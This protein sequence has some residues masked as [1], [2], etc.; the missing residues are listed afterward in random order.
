MPKKALI[1]YGPT[2]IGKTS[3]AL[4]WAQRWKGELVSADSRQVYQGMDI[5]T[6]KDVGQAKFHPQEQLVLENCP[7][8]RGYYLVEGVKI[9]LLDILKPSQRFSSYQWAQLARRV[10]KDIWRRKKLPLVVGGSAFY[11]KT[12]LDDLNTQGIPPNWSLRKRL[13]KC[14]V[15]ELQRELKRIWPTRWQQLNHSDRHNPRR[16]IR[17]LEIKEAAKPLSSPKNFWR[18]ACWQGVYL[19]ASLKFIRQ[20]ISLRIRQRLKAGLL[21]EIAG[22]LESGYRWE[23]PGLN[24]LAYKEFRL[25]FAGKQQRAKAIKKWQQDEVEYARRQQ[26]WFRHDQRFWK[27]NV[28]QKNWRQLIN[29]KVE[30]WYYEKE[31]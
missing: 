31:K 27:V 30:T 25:F 3:L 29:K 4:K 15:A 17:A 6:G 1:I 28:E 23:D 19:T 26:L 11:L 12:L 16:L 2:A 24:C 5:G 7:L 14:S 22:L 20:R 18:Q 13:E 21:E 10:I 8:T 9:W